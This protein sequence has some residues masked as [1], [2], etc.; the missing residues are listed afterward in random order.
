MVFLVFSLFLNEYFN[1]VQVALPLKGGIQW[2]QIRE[3][4]QG[5]LGFYTPIEG[6][7][8]SCGWALVYLGSTRG[9]REAAS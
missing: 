9:A 8:Q 4:I 5:F 3:R 2:V 1:M 6:C 7:I